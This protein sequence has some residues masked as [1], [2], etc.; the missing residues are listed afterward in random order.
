[1][2]PCLQEPEEQSHDAAA[3]AAGGN[4]KAADEKELWGEKTL[5]HP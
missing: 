4:E 5:D 1:M 3:K 2:Q